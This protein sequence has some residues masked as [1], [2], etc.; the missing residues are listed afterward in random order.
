MG[1]FP[2]SKHGT[3]FKGAAETAYPAWVFGVDSER[4]HLRLCH[5]CFVTYVE[6]CES[7]LTEAIEGERPRADNQRVCVVCGG[8]NTESALFVTVYPKGQP[9][10]QFFGPLCLDDVAAAKAAWL[11]A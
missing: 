10:R 8:S 2:C 7:S 3:F 11:I 6:Q 9:P 5:E 4:T 1:F